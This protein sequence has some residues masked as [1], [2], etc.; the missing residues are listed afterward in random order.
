MREAEKHFE[1]LPV[2]MREEKDRF[3]QDFVARRLREY[4]MMKAERE[5]RRIRHE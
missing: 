4:E 5:V 2:H 1:D 3:I